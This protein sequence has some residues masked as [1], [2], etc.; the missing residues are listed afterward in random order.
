MARVLCGILV[1]ITCFKRK[2]ET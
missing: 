2:H 1:C